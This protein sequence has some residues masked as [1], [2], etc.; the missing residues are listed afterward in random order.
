MTCRELT[1]CEEIRR[2][3]KSKCGSKNFERPGVN[4]GNCSE[5]RRLDIKSRVCIY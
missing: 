4:L 1:E 5:G 2:K 3:R